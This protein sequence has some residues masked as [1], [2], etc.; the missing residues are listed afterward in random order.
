MWTRGDI[1]ATKHYDLL[2]R[3]NAHRCQSVASNGLHI[4]SGISFGQNRRSRY[5]TSAAGFIRGRSEHDL[6]NGRDQNRRHVSYRR[7]AWKETSSECNMGAFRLYKIQSGIQ[8][9]HWVCAV[10]LCSLDLKTMDQRSGCNFSC[11]PVCLLFAGLLFIRSHG[12]LFHSCKSN[13]DAGR[14]RD[15]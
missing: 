8:H 9:F 4:F 13:R 12:W 1:L 14:C 11:S 3:I 15:R 10:H 2:Q 7:R 6:W 5:R